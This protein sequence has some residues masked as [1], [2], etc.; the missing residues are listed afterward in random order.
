M[1]TIQL[2]YL[3]RARQDMCECGQLESTWH[4]IAVWG[5]YKTSTVGSLRFFFF[6]S[7]RRRHT[8][9]QGDWSSDVCSSDLGDAW[10]A[11]MA[12]GAGAAVR[13]QRRH[14]PARTSRAS[15]TLRGSAPVLPGGARRLPR[16]IG[17]ASCRERV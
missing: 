16:Q 7:S 11:G 15:W 17:R 10:V 2:V 9:L 5:V 13:G 1:Y 4:V 14:D 3:Q 12:R 6:F 8:R